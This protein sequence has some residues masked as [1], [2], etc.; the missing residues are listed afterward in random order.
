MTTEIQYTSNSGTDGL[1]TRDSVISAN[2]TL[3]L[4]GEKNLLTGNFLEFS[5]IEPT[6]QLLS[7]LISTANMVLL[8]QEDII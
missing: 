6:D 3:Y 2:S 8:K 5:S 1:P 7:G 4:T